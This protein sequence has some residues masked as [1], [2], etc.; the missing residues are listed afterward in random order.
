MDGKNYL[1]K[2]DAQT[3]FNQDYGDAQNHYYN[4]DAPTIAAKLR[5]KGDFAGADAFEKAHRI[6]T[7][8]AA[9]PILEDCKAAQR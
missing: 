5:A 4:I 9:F 8:S 6:Q 7:F 3:A 2:A 1:T